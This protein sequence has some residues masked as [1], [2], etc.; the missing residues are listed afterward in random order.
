MYAHLS[1]PF[2]FVVVRARRST[3]RTVT[4]SSLTNCMQF[5]H[6][7]IDPSQGPWLEPAVEPWRVVR[8]GD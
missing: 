3:S 6:I 8:C 1:I 7:T 2:Q 5:N 4:P